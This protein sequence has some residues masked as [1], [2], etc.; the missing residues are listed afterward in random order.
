MVLWLLLQPAD[1]LR[2]LT[3]QNVAVSLPALQPVATRL[4]E[5]HMPASCLQG[6]S[7]GF[8]TRGW[9]ALTTLSLARASAD[10]ANLT[11]T[12]N[13][14]ALDEVNILNFRHQGGSLQLDQLTGGC[15]QI[16]RLRFQLDSDLVQGREVS[17]PSCSLQKLGRLANL[18]MRTGEELLPPSLDLDL[19]ASLSTFMVESDEDSEDV[20]LF[21]VLRQAAKCIRRGAHL[22][23]LTCYQAEAYLQPAGWGANLDEQ[24]GRLGGQ[25]S[26]LQELEVWGCTEQLLSALGAVI[27]SAPHLTCVE[28]TITEWLPCMKLPPVCSASLETITMTFDEA[29]RN[30]APLPR[31]APLVLTFLPGCTRLKHVLVRVSNGD[32]AEGTAAKI[33]CHS[34]SPMCVV[35]M[36]VHARGA[37]HRRVHG[38]A[39]QFSEMGVELLPGPLSPPSVQRAYTVLHACHAAGPQQPLRWGHVVVP[40]FH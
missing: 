23:R 18:Y 10:N 21:W 37:E 38:Y 29:P 35:P 24:Y 1:K 27:S 25:L 15:P 5:L 20:D 22:R 40:G 36:D 13:L 2:K 31:E 32:L 11:A 7:E 39:S 16:R 30:E 9:T 6:C 33:R 14:P 19:P 34:G 3:L 26:R 4:H 17:G 12:L 8:L 28:I